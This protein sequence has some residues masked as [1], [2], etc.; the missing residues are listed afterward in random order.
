MILLARWRHS[1]WPRR[2]HEISP[3][4]ECYRPLRLAIWE[5]YLYTPSFSILCVD[6]LAPFGAMTSADKV[7][8]KFADP[9]YTGPGLT[10]SGLKN[11]QTKFTNTFS[12]NNSG[13]LIPICLRRLFAIDIK[14]AFV[15]TITCCCITRTND[16]LNHNL[17]T[18]WHIYYV[19]RLKETS[20]QLALRLG[21]SCNKQS[22]MKDMI[23]CSVGSDMLF[24]TF[25]GHNQ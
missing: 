8:A 5:V 17:L 14:S 13:I 20:K 12:W 2:F 1:K 21:N 7:M 25:S 19:K 22:M 10:H 9:I 11:R 24:P 16:D 23:R 4:F 3:I 15:Q 18:M 6:D